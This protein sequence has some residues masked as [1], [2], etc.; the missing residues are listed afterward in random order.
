VQWTSHVQAPAPS[1]PALVPVES[2]RVDPYAQA[3]PYGLPPV[4][5]GAYVPT[6]NAVLPQVP[7]Q[8]VHQ[9]H[10]RAAVSS[11]VFGAITFCLSLVGFIPSSPVL[12]YSVGGV[13]AIAGGVRALVLRRAGFG[14]NVWAPVLAIVLG[15]LAL[16]FMVSGLIIRETRNSYIPESNSLSQSDTGIGNGGA[17]S[18]LPS[19][20]SFAAD[21]NLT[22]Y[23]RSAAT[24]AQSIYA[25]YN[26]GQLTSP[27]PT[28]PA[29]VTV[30]SD[31]QVTFPTGVVATTIPAGEVLHYGVSPTLGFFTISV[32]GGNLSEI[33]VY[34]SREN[35]FSWAC[36]SEA[37][38]TCPPGGIALEPSSGDSSKGSNA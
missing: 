33:A 3:N 10:N 23:E 20:P 6:Q 9:A 24:I 17:A 11:V 4:E 29:D 32:T 38:A 21:P 15:A 18:T 5:Q 30:A 1:A 37:Q 13:F 12:Y 27:T 22:A 34:E 35:R 2:Q 14:T 26:G 28:W 16:V 31:G 36:A 19:P 7:M 25:N 8:A